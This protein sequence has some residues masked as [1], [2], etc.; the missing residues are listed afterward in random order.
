[1]SHLQTKLVAIKRIEVPR[2]SI[3]C[4][5]S[6]PQIE[7]GAK[8]FLEAKGFIN[9]LIL[10]KINSISEEATPSDRYKVISGFF[11]YF[12]A[13]WAKHLDPSQEWVQAIIVNDSL[14]DNLGQQ[15][16]LFRISVDSIEF[17][18]DL[19]FELELENLDIDKWLDKT[20]AGKSV[21]DCFAAA[22]KLVKLYPDPADRQNAI[23]ELETLKEQASGSTSARA[24]LDNFFGEA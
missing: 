8:L 7:K 22:E 16:E 3:S 19:D 6:H 21:E 15:I 12:C 9:P 23:A 2:V 13:V 18:D 4:Q 1:M 20:L 5:Y 17:D 10:E 11:E 14:A 24:K